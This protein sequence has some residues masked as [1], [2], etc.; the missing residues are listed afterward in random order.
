MS[1]INSNFLTMKL[2]LH[3]LL[4]FTLVICQ[5]LYCIVI[6]CAVDSFIY[7]LGRVHTAV[8]SGVNHETNSVT[9][10]WF[11][12]GETKG[13]EVFI[14]FKMVFIVSHF[15]VM[16]LLIHMFKGFN[17]Q[18]LLKKNKLTFFVGSN[19]LLFI[20][21][22]IFNGRQKKCYTSAHCRPLGHHRMCKPIAN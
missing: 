16:L 19:C 3:F 5:K 17:L 22:T 13:K 20:H 2:V 10:E 18:H 11:E 7:A 12:R 15:V 14:Q 4:H 6:G 8:I 1:G 9:V 21:K